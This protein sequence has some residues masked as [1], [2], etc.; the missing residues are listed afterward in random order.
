MKYYSDQNRTC[1]QYESGNYALTSGNRQ[2]I[3][4][5]QEHT[6]TPNINVIPIRYQGS[7]DRNVDDFAEGIKEWTGTFTYFPQDWKMLAFAIGSVQD[8]TGSHIITENNSDDRVQPTN[9]PLYSLTIEDSKNIG[10]AGSNFIRTTIG[11]VIDSFEL[12]AT[13][14][15]V[16]SCTVNYRAQD[17]TLSSG[18]IVALSPTTT[19]PYVFNNVKLY[20]PSGTLIDNVKDVSFIVNNNLEGGFYLNGSKTLNEILPM[21]RDYEVS[22]TCNMDTG[23]ANILYDSYYIA[24]ST[25]NSMMLVLGKTGS[26]SL[27]MSGC[28]MTEMDVPSPMEGVQ[29]QSFTFIPEHVYPV[30][31]DSITKYNAW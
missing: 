31:Y 3:G 14:G 10:T 30:A 7:T 20:I 16:V 18:A 5:I 1:F 19:S 2:W 11:A 13:L 8:L 22:A 12:N 24:G 4:L 26:L 25:F 28:K 23:N 6:L 29:E 9:T 21:N 15:D 17:S 27:I